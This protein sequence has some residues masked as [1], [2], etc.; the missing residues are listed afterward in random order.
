[1]NP[2]QTPINKPV[3]ADLNFKN[4]KI[5]KFSKDN[6]N[7]N[8]ILSYNEKLILFEIEKENENEFP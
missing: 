1:M 4:K 8:I 3:K 2:T 6:I 5:L 7:Y